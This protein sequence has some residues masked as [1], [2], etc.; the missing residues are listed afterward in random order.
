MQ[1]KPTAKYDRA[2]KLAQKQPKPSRE[3]Y[4]LLLAADKGGDG[5]ATYALATWHLFGSPFTKTNYRV[6]NSMLKRAADNGVADAAYDLAVS[7]EKGLGIGKSLPR[8]FEYYV[9]AALLGDA[10]SHYEI[11]R[12][13]FHGTGVPRNRRLA[14]AWLA[15]AETLGVKETKR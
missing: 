4:D 13:Y 8:A 1:A 14:E 6:A 11:G 5:R 9:R 3:V 15:K 2:L 10:Q 7:Y 12:M